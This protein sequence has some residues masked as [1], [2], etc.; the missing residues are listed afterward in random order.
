MYVYEHV[1]VRVRVSACVG[2][3]FTDGRGVGVE[4]DIRGVG[5]FDPRCLWTGGMGGQ[6]F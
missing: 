1:C 5:V 6:K 4:L 2:V 3:F